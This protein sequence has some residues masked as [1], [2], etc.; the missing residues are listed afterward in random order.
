MIFSLILFVGIIA[1]IFF[2]IL[3]LMR[4]YDSIQ[5]I[6]EVEEEKEMKNKKI[7]NDLQKKVDKAMDSGNLEE[8]GR[9]IENIRDMLERSKKEVEKMNSKQINEIDEIAEKVNSMDFN[10]QEDM[11]KILEDMGEELA[12]EMK[13]LSENN[14]NIDDRLK[15]LESTI[16]SDE[17][18]TGWETFVN[19]TEQDIKP[20]NDNRSNM[21][22]LIDET[23]KKVSDYVINYDITTR[24]K[25]NVK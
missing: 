9:K 17:D 14:D 2:T 24:K 19:D 10:N 3:F 22:K 11:M 20:L 21:K 1:A 18:F 16:A 6:K 5:K 25:R 15:I 12:N 4:M 8:M 23:K 13:I 7:Y